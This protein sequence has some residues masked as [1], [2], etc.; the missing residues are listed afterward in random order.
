MSALEAALMTLR[1]SD[2]RITAARRTVLD[3]L[4]AE[5][6]HMTAPDLVAAVHARVPQIGRASVYRALE[7]LTRLGIV[8][9][10]TLGGGS[11]TYMLAPAG[12][13]HHLVCRA[14]GRTIEFDEC[15]LGDIAGRL[16]AAFG[17]Q[18][19]GHLVEVYGRCADCRPAASHAGS[20]SA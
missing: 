18:I 19:E 10:S 13:H 2:C 5:S 12:H 7:L 9:A 15:A 8:Q 1:R 20:A 17:F 11:A 3:V 6:G 16:A 4:A 14:C